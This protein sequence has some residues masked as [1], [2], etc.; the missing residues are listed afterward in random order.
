VTSNAAV[1]D[2]S[3]LSASNHAMACEARS[4]LTKTP[5]SLS[6]WLFYDDTGS[7]LFEQITRLPEYYLTRTERQLFEVHSEAILGEMGVDAVVPKATGTN[8]PVQLR[9]ALT[10]AELGAGTASKTG[11][12]LRALA[13]V[14]RNVVYQ[15][16]DV[17]VS[18]LDH[19]KNLE[20]QIA[21]LTV[22]SCVSNYVA[23]EYQLERTARTRVLALYIGSSIGNF[24][25]DEARTVLT[26]LRAQLAPGDGLLLGTDLAPGPHKSVERLCTAYDDAQ[27]VT[28]AFNRNVLTRLNREL[29]TNFAVEQFQHVAI[30]NAEESRVEMHLRSRISQSVTIPANSAGLLATIHFRGGETIHTENSYKFTQERVAELLSSAGFQSTKTF[31]DKQNLFALTL[32]KVM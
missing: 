11:I 2:V 6:P 14:Q 22:R 1:F 18:A 3:E 10:V 5:K 20:R 8:Q 19:A 28:A 21:G 30:W 15:P 32:A 4:G 12:L 16:I 27:G 9:N 31:T 23:E 25:P 26:R 17:S 24:A 29:G 7:D 13:S